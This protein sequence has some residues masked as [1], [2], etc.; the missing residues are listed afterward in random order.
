GQPEQTGHVLPDGQQ[1]A[2]DHFAGRQRGE[3]HLVEEAAAAVADQ[4]AAG[5]DRRQPGDRDPGD[6]Q[7][8]FR[9]LAL[10]S[11][12][13]ANTNQEN[14]EPGEDPAGPLDTA[15]VAVAVVDAS[16]ARALPQ[17]VADLP[18]PGNELV[19]GLAPPVQSSL[20]A[21]KGRQ[22]AIAKPAQR[23]EAADSQA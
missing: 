7:K 10:Q 16:V 2:V 17:R 13:L 12:G 19:E 3:Q 23:V 11:P 18:A 14:E 21:A 4:A 20:K 22:Q 9:R 5:E 15:D 1:R 8:D 6:R